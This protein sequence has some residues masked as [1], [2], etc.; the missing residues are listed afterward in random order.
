VVDTLLHSKMAAQLREI[1]EQLNKARRLRE[2]AEHRAEQEGHRA[3]QE[4]H[5]AEQEGHRAEQERQRA[6]T[7]DGR[8]AHAEEQTRRRILDELLEA[9]QDLSQSMLVQTDKS[10]STQGSTTNPKGK[11]YPTTLRP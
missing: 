1:E 11:Y 8:A 5:R 3:E 4:G 10:L 9:C 7:A 2:L 6:E